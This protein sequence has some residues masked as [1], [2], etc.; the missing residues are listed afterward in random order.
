MNKESPTYLQTS[1]AAAMTLGFKT[2]RFYRDA[3]LYCINLLL[4]YNSGCAGNC[5]YCGLS[6]RRPGEYKD[7][8]FIRVEWP[9]Y[10]F[11][12]IL[13]GIST[14]SDKV[15]RVCLSMVTNK[16]A[17]KDTIKITKTHSQNLD[18]PLSLL[19]SPTILDKKHLYNFRENGADM[20]GIAIDCATPVLFEK[21][22]GKN[23][24]GP[25][26]WEKYWKCYED[27]IEIFGKRNVGIH[28]IVGLGETE[29]EMI[30]TIQKSYLMGGSTHL[31][32]FFPEPDSFLSKHP[33]PPMGQ[34][35]RIQLAR[36]LIDEGISVFED[37]C[38]D[39]NGR[40]TGFGLSDENISKIIEPGTPFMTSGWPNRGRDVAC[41]RPYANC[42]PG[43][44]IR[45]FPF[46]PKNEDI[47]KIKVEL[48]K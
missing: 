23:V 39:E 3:K 7:K 45:N 4:T 13:D 35:R 2:G 24:N 41:N 14:N 27:A 42:L 16:R 22:R 29:K 28:L 12:G 26:K 31:F 48:K 9:I 6:M 40:V 38:F 11:T 43:P 1:L 44:N 10:K 47:K 36:F 32:S 37:F 17:I 18:I 20:I 46:L 5:G 21:F 25:H 19:I 8:S 15:K 30:E 33:Q 34:Y